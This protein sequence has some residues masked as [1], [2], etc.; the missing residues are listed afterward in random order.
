M[1]QN[2]TKDLKELEL[3]QKRLELELEKTKFE[4]EQKKSE[5]SPNSQSQTPNYLPENLSTIAHLLGF[6]PPVGIILVWI[7]PKIHIILKLFSTCFGA[8]MC[9]FWIFGFRHVIIPFLSHF[10]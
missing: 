2:N 3:E 4:L 10:F 5:A 9:V 7:D 6:L 1:D 8:A